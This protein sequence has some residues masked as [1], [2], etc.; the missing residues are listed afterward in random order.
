MDPHSEDIVEAEESDSDAPRCEECGAAVRWDPDADALSCAY[1]GTVRPVERGDETILER[2]LAAAAEVARGLGIDLRVTDCGQCGAR[3][4]F[5]GAST[6]TACAFC[7]SSRVLDQDCNRNALRPESLV[8]LDVGR[9]EVEAAFDKWLTGLWFRPNALKGVK[10]ADAQG[11]YVPYWTFDCH[12]HSD[13]TAMSGT[14]YYVTVPVVTTVNGK[15]RTRMKRVRKVRW[16]PA[17][18]ERSD[19]FDDL[20]V[21]ASRGLSTGLLDRLGGFDTTALVPYRS[22]YLAGWRAEEYAIDLEQG[23]EEG[24]RRVEAR[25]HQRCAG[26]VPGDT[27][28]ALSVRN[29]VSDVRFRH[30]LLPVWS[31]VY[32]YRGKAFPVLVNGQTGRVVGK[33]PWSWVKILALLAT[34]GA[35][36]AALALGS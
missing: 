25:Q 6:S 9:T 16:R 13:W 14:Y 10:A 7:G 21:P 8:P 2:P 28:R 24:H 31:L 36:V 1:C 20:L 15:V 22:E 27:Q 33:A 29:T 30:V 3:I 23:W 5:E 32:R 35:G 17:A 34:L 4:T 12:V 26:D 19:V 18:G 11:V